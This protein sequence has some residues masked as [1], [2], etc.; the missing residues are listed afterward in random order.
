MDANL[1]AYLPW[2]LFAWRAWFTVTDTGGRTATSN[3]VTWQV[4][5]YP[6]H[7]VP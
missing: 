4:V 7:G 3:T 2:L 5:F 6:V 1:A